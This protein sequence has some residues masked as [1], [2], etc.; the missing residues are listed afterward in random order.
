[1]V[2]IMYY[3]CKFIITILFHVLD[4]WVWNLPPPKRTRRRV[5]IS[6][7]FKTYLDVAQRGVTVQGRRGQNVRVAVELYARHHVLVM[8]ERRV[9]FFHKAATGSP[10]PHAHRPI[11]IYYNKPCENGNNSHSYDIRIMIFKTNDVT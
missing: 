2:T 7:N 1:M 11:A 9:R 4:T 6:T 10:F 8:R 5:R 3:I